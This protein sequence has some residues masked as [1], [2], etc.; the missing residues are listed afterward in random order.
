MDCVALWKT[1]RIVKS[2]EKSWSCAA[3]RSHGS[4]HEKPA[5]LKICRPPG[6]Y[7]NEIAPEIARGD[8]FR[9]GAK[10]PPWCR[11]S[12]MDPRTM[13]VPRYFEKAARFKRRT[14]LFWKW[15]AFIVVMHTAMNAHGPILGELST[16]NVSSLKEIMETRAQWN[17]PCGAT[18]AWRCPGRR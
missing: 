8:V 14:C 15:A 11:M 18:R 6:I 7:G 9:A 5:I 4:G 2:Q 10:L 3:P 13:I 1:G 16:A 17:S 12:L